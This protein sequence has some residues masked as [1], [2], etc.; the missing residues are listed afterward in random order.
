MESR[1]VF[2]NQ[3]AIPVVLN[4]PYHFFWS[5]SGR[6][7]VHKEVMPM[8][9]QKT[10]L[11]STQSTGIFKDADNGEKQKIT[12]FMAEIMVSGRV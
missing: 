6:V 9:P 4:S 7:S 2:E 3:K 5:F 10:V 11:Q 12:F 1:Q 8:R